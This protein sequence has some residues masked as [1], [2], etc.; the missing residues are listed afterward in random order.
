MENKT[1]QNKTKQKNRTAKISLN[2]KRTSM[3]FTIPDLKLYYKAIVRKTTWYWCK[4]R[5]ISVE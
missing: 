1:K 5:S 4:N 2:N 3:R